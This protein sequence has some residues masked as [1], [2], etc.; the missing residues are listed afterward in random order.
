MNTTFFAKSVSLIIILLSLA[1]CG[2][3]KPMVS[4][5][6]VESVTDQGEV[7]VSMEAVL[8][9]GNVSLAD[10]TLPIIVP[11]TQQI[12]GS[13]SMY[14]NMQGQNKFEIEVN[15]SAIANV[16]AVV[17][18]LPN[19]NTLPL[20]RDND[21]IVIPIQNKA[22]VYL[23]FSD[24]VAALGATVAIRGLD[25]VGQA[26]G[27]ASLFPTFNINQ[28]V[29]SAGLYTSRENGKNGF[30][31]FADISSLID[32]KD[33]LSKPVRFSR[34]AQRQ[35]VEHDNLRLNYNSINPTRRQKRKMDNKL[36]RLHRNRARL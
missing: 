19:G 11:R 32:T 16:N 26:T 14:T 8:S 21:V 17:A 15:L 10:L 13:V 25:S 27:T 29:G 20:I 1:S 3:Q 24:G 28:V 23:A 18:Q 5:I 12:I 33:L 4:D 9:I 6:E 31:I 36:Y 7:F 30:G 2:S 35:V 22:N 34:L